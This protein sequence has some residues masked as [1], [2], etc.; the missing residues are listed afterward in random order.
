MARSGCRHLLV[1]LR[2]DGAWT[3][4]VSPVVCLVAALMEKAA[5]QISRRLAG[6]SPRGLAV[7]VLV[8]VG[9][10]HNGPTGWWW[11]GNALAGVACGYWCP[12]SAQKTLAADTA[13]CLL[14]GSRP[15]G[16][17]RPR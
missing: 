4:P 14:L 11:R 3:L 8:L 1:A 7:A 10:G 17:A 16:S 9:P 6:P 13:S 5:V 2:A 15:D 12:S